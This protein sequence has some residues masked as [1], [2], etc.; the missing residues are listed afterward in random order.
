MRLEPNL[1]LILFGDFAY[2]SDLLV[3]DEIG[4]V[5][6]RGCLDGEKKKSRWLFLGYKQVDLRNRLEDSQ[7]D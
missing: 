2:Q 5:L 1:E 6:K 7:S 3:R 4:V